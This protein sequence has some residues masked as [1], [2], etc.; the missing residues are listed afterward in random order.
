MRLNLALHGILIASAAIE[1]TKCRDEYYLEAMRQQLLRQ[2][3]DLIEQIPAKPFFYLEVPASS[4]TLRF[5]KTTATQPE[6]TAN[7]K[8][9]FPGEAT[10]P[11]PD[12]TKQTAA[13]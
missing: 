13:L 9:C 10:W 4:A 6:K 1:E 11:N 7:K 3:E 2:N 8:V 12:V 5:G